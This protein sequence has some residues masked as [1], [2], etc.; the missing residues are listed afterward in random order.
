[1]DNPNIG[2]IVAPMFAVLGI[3]AVIGICLLIRKSIR[4]D[5]QKAYKGLPSRLGLY[6]I[7][8]VFAAIGSVFILLPILFAL[9]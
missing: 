4:T 2:Y 1:M 6:C 7:L 5:A 3:A 8:L 9:S